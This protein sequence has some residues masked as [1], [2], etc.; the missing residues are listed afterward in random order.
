M[1][2]IEVNRGSGGAGPH[3]WSA[4]HQPLRRAAARARGRSGPSLVLRGLVLVPLILLVVV[5]AGVGATGLVAVSS[6]A[7]LSQDLPDPQALSTLSFDE[8]TLVYDRT[9]KVQ[10]ARFQ[11]AS[12]QVVDYR[13]IP[14]LVLDATT[15]AEDR[16]FWANDGYDV[17]GDGRGGDRR[18]S[19]A[20]GAAPRRSPSS[21]SGPGCSRRTSSSP[22]PTV[23]PAQ[24]Q[25]DHPGGPPHRRRSPA[26]P[27]SSR[28]SPPT[29]T[30]SSTATTRTGS[31]PR[32]R[33]TSA[34]RS[35]S[36]LTPAQAALL[37]ALPQSPHGARP[38]PL[39]RPQQEGPA[40]GPAE[41]AADRP[42]RLD[43][44]EPRR[45]AAGRT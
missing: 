18:R 6:I 25:G 34:S 1:P 3:R 20:T 32:P 43:P 12:R 24:G 45:L 26:R 16:T 36:K 33:S 42:P 9:G 29:S 10:L 11:R 23:V 8:P 7:A 22:A 5:V 40:G 19:R 39:R 30:R 17:H 13:D 21:S 27:A 4:S 38:V 37:A 35:S 14:R 44:A 15:T 31:R 28:S 2:S 41:R